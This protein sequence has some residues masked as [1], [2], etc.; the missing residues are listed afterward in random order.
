MGFSLL[1]SLRGQGGGEGPVPARCGNQESAPRP[2]ACLRF[3]DNTQYFRMQSS[4][5]VGQSGG[6]F[7]VPSATS[8]G[9]TNAAGPNSPFDKPFY[10]N[11]NL[12]GMQK[13]S[14]LACVPCRRRAFVCRPA[15][16][17]AAA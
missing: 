15:A 7:T 12:A 8:S 1:S 4:S 9:V 3:L 5:V 13:G 11:L 16:T 2:P 10:I 6:W 17:A 14:A